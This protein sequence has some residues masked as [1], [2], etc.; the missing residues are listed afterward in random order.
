MTVAQQVAEMSKSR[1]R[2]L[3]RP[4]PPETPAMPPFQR[5]RRSNSATV[6]ETQKI[7]AQFMQTRANLLISSQPGLTG[8]LSGH[9]RPGGFAHRP[10]EGGG[11][12]NFVSA[13]DPETNL[14]VHLN[15]TWVR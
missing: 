9:G 8:F 14:W 2:K 10:S 3:R 1:S 5:P 7:I 11:S 12:F 6:A 4:M 13:A 15:G